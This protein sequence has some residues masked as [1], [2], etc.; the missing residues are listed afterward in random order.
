MII[1]NNDINVFLMFVFILTCAL[2]Q[3]DAQNGVLVLDGSEKLSGMRYFGNF[4]EIAY[5]YINSL[6][7][8]PEN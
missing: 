2:S 7:N 5:N 4:E 6:N 8:P 1:N 3:E